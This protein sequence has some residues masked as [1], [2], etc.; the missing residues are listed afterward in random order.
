MKPLEPIGVSNYK[1]II[2]PSSF[3]T[4]KFKC[5]SSSRT[6]ESSLNF[7]WQSILTRK[8]STFWHFRIVWIVDSCCVAGDLLWKNDQQTMA[9]VFSLDTWPT[10]LCR[11]SFSVFVFIAQCDASSSFLFW[12]SIKTRAQQNCTSSSTKD[13]ISHFMNEFSM[14]YRK[15]RCFT[16]EPDTVCNECPRKARKLSAEQF[17]KIFCWVDVLHWTLCSFSI[18]RCWWICIFHITFWKLN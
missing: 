8:A 11:S 13:F 16:S 17:K 15:V 18:P 14:C 2:R 12:I 9:L 10:T 3:T 5:K 1:Q 4:N 7:T 6:A